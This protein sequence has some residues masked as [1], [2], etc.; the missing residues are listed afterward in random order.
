MTLPRELPLGAQPAPAPTHMDW[1]DPSLASSQ[2]ASRA[3][4]FLLVGSIV[5]GACVDSALIVPVILRVLKEYEWAAWI[6]SVT[7]A[8]LSAVAMFVAGRLIRGARGNPPGPGG[9]STPAWFVVAAWLATGFMIAALRIADGLME[10]TSAF[11][12]PS[13][14]AD[15]GPNVTPYVAAFTFLAVYLLVG[16]LAFVKAFTSRNDAFSALRLE[17]ARLAH[18]EFAHEELTALH[19]RLS[20]NVDIRRHEI[21][22]HQD[23]LHTAKAHNSAL[24]QE[25]KHYFR[26]ELAKL[27]QDPAVTGLTSPLHP[28]NPAYRDPADVLPDGTRTPGRGAWG[29]RDHSPGSRRPRRRATAQSTDPHDELRS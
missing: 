29:P 28:S 1:E 27:R 7:I 12:D 2:G 14:V 20:D 17:E 16:V 19:Q 13:A 4:Q 24:A 18:C 25:A 11:A 8:I 3:G 15:E 9:A 26:H 22:A 6:V 5:L 10:P 23:C 21:A